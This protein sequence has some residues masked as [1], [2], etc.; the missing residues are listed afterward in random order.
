M[1]GNGVLVAVVD[2]GVN[3]TYLNS[4]GKYPAFNRGLSWKPS[5]TP[6]GHVLGSMPVDHGTMVAFDAV[7]PAPNCTILDIALLQ[8][9]LSGSSSMSGT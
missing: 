9:R 7:L 3:I 6:P 4:V 1:D 2:T 5:T 8:T